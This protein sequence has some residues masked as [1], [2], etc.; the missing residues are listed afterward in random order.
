MAPRIKRARNGSYTIK[1]PKEEREL[2]RTLIPQ[3]RDLLVGGDDL[4]VRLFPPAYANDPELNA[5]YTSMV[6]DDLLEGRLAALDGIEETI[7]ATSLD[8]AQL[9]G[10]M[11]VLN[12]MR[13]VL[14]TRL[15]IAEDMD[16]PDD[17]DPDAALYAV[18]DYLTHLVA[19]IV[20]A[21]A[22]W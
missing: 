20:D 1:L 12:D 7:D 9:T 15:D 11:G 22:D 8:E 17:D 13:L 18:Y 10:W 21:L 16:P 3:L 19:L 2:L 14:G 4:T 5:E 6:R